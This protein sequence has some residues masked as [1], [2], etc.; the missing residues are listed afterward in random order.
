MRLRGRRA[1]RRLPNNGSEGAE[2]LRGHHILGGAPSAQKAQIIKKGAE[3]HCVLSFRRTQRPGECRATSRSSNSQY[4]VGWPRERQVARGCRLVGKALS[5]HQA[6]GSDDSTD[7]EDV[8]V[9]A[10][11]PSGQE[12]LS[13]DRESG[14]V[15]RASD[16]QGGGKLPSRW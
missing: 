1:V 5:G 3:R 12:F 2:R 9:L 8:D 13:I 4:G 11:C 7:D 14:S 16:S 6:P 10:E 15:G